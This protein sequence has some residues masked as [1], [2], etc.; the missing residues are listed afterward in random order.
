MCLAVP[1][2]IVEIQDKDAVVEVYNVRRDVR[3]DLVEGCQVGDYVLV[4]AGF[5]INKVDE[6][7]AQQTLELLNQL[8]EAESPGDS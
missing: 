2:K 8:M 5:A 6:K 3:L 1:A 7:S 4:H